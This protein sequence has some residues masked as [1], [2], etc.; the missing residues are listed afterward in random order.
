MDRS[1]RGVL[2]TDSPALLI[3]KRSRHR[4]ISAFCSQDGLTGFRSNECASQDD[5]LILLKYIPVVPLGNLL[6]NLRVSF[7]EQKRI[8]GFAIALGIVVLD[9]Y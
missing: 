9:A 2:L 3:L 7:L 5:L 6:E 1:G 4:K 8:D